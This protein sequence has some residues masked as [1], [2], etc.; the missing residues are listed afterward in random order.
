LHPLRESR[1]VDWLFNLL[2][3][4]FAVGVVSACLYL[5]Y[6]AYHCLAHLILSLIAGG[7]AVYRPMSRSAERFT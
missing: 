4:L 3:P 2:D 7:R 1:I 5:M 6:G